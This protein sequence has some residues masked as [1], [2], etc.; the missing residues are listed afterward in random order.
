MIYSAEE[1]EKIRQADLMVSRTIAEVAKFLEPGVS[2]KKLDE[3]AEEFIRDNGGIPAFKG[4]HGFP[5]TL[6]ISENEKVVHGIP[7]DDVIFKEGDIISIDCGVLLDGFFGDSAYTFALGE[8]SPEA[9]KLMEVTKESLYRGIEQARA[10][11]RVGDIGH[12]IQSYVESFGYSVPREITGHGVGRHL[13]EDPSIPNY[14]RRGNGKRLKAGMVIA[15]EPMVIAGSKEIEILDD[16][17]TIVSADGGLAA[18]Y[19]HSIAITDGEAIILS[20]FS[21]IEEVLKNKN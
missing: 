2:S 9:K 6:C 5:A 16:N 21:I 4:Y 17:W 3:I 19:E 8:V 13:H 10:G 11:N 14:G 7:S 12:A 15:I 1:I 20:D 18:H